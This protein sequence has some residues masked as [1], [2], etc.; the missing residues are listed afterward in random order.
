M[1]TTNGLERLNKELKRRTRVAT[2][3]PNTNSCL[4]LVSALP[5]EQDE[6]WMTAKIYLTM[7][8]SAHPTASTQN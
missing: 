1:R 6:E 2:L 8:P 4:R 3:R 7:K 5:A